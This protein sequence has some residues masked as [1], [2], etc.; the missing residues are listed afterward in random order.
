MGIFK[1]ETFISVGLISTVLYMGGALFTCTAHATEF[2]Q[3]VKKLC[4]QMNEASKKSDLILES[5]LIS[6]IEAL[7]NK[8]SNVACATKLSKKHY[9]RVYALAPNADQSGYGACWSEAS[10]PNVMF[11]TKGE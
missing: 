6:R 7:S 10:S 8:D 9:K 11:C 4:I 3:D 1:V 5:K 2:T